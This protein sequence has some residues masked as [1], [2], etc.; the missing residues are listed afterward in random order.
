MQNTC[1]TFDPNSLKLIGS[2]GYGRVFETADGKIIKAIMNKKACEEASLEMAKQLKVYKAFNILNQIDTNTNQINNE[3]VKLVQ[4]YVKVS[5]PLKSCDDNFKIGKDVY[6]CF[7]MMTKLNGIPIKVYDELDISMDKIDPGYLKVLY[8]NNQDIMLQLS[9]NSEFTPN[10]YGVEYSKKLI[11]DRNPPRGFFTNEQA[12]II[13]KL[14][15]NNIY[16]LPLSSNSIKQIMG[17]IYGFIFYYARIVPTDIELTLGYNSSGEFEINVLDFGMTIDLDD[18]DNTP[19]LPRN[20]NIIDIFNSSLTNEQKYEK[21]EEETKLDIGIDL[22][23]DV[24]DV[25]TDVECNKGWGIAK[26]LV[27][28]DK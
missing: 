18:I 14:N 5:K 10:F 11:S 12:E 28:S 17:F 23:C 16:Q 13:N 15:K 26:K 8:E 21:L 24:N 6:S 7:I 19:I 3:L 25:N 9:L 20:R 2:G 1:I 27:N 22:Y 4:K